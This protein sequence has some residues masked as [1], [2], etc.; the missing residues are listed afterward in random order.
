MAREQNFLLGLGERL[1]LPVKVPSGGGD[2][3]PRTTSRRRDLESPQDSSAQR[4][5]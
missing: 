3:N 4:R 2:K 5:H 1:T